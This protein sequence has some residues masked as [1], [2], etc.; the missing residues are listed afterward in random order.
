MMVSKEMQTIDV[1]TIV[2]DVH[3][4]DPEYNMALLIR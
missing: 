3:T 4:K 2:E 1:E